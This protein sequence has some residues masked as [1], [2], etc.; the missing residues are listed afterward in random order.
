MLKP[1]ETK[2]SRLKVS[3]CGLMSSLHGCLRRSRVFTVQLLVLHVHLHRPPQRPDVPLTKTCR[4]PSFYQLQEEG[5]LSEDGLCEHL[6]EVPGKGNNWGDCPSPCFRLVFTTLHS[7]IDPSW[8]RMQ[9]R[10]KTALSS[11]HSLFT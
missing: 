8:D 4:P 11:R 6:K 3:E 7:G 5:V 1:P 10:G 9:E 2:Q